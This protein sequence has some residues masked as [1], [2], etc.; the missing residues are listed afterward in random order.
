MATLLTIVPPE[1][2]DLSTKKKKKIGAFVQKL[3]DE[4]TLKKKYIYT[5]ELYN[6]LSFLP[7][8]VG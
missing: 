5:D 8:E 4:Q 3:I 1:K 6:L 2:E 7:F